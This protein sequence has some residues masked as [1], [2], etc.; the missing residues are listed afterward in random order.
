MSQ[1]TVVNRPGAS[2]GPVAPNVGKS[3]LTTIF[4]IVFVDILGFGLILPLL[5]YY[6]N[7][8]GATT[9]ITGLLV[10]SYAAAQL[11]GAPLLGRLSD[12]Y[13]RR[14]ILLVSIAGTALGFLL[15]GLA[16]P[17][18]RS[19]GNLLGIATA[20]NG[21]VLALMFASRVL[22]GLTGGNISVA[23]AYITDVTTKENRAVGLG[24]IGA[25]FG[26]GFIL[27]PAA[28]GLLSQFG[29][30]VPAYVAAGIA[31]LNVVAVYLFLPESLT[32]EKRLEMRE[33]ER[34]RLNFSTLAAAFR[35]PRVGPLLNTRFWFGMAFSMFQSI[36]SIYAA[37]KPLA[38]SPVGTGLV[39]TYVG[40]LAAIVQGFAI[41][42]ITRRY[43]DATLLISAAGA[44]AV[45]FV[46]WGA[47]PNV[48]TL[49]IVLIPLSVGGGILNTLLSSVLTKVVEPEEVGGTL[50]LATSVE[51]LTRVLAPAL[52]GALL[53]WWGVWGPAL[54]AAIVMAWV[55]YF[56]MR[57][58][59]GEV[60]AAQ[61][62]QGKPAAAA[63]SH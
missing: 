58:I 43:S 47:V 21:I 13:G 3:R 42:K 62:A 18:G 4:L 36:F 60:P 45:G 38:L 20:V 53:T 57:R 29:Y 55:T 6:A 41:G 61:A 39:L 50:G 35:R 2:H 25:A 5:P 31:T 15:L 51:S 32:P 30:A 12:R 59:A 49:L 54:F 10:A 56:I 24:L 8:Y 7:Q 63:I 44:M 33:F 16:E 34:P 37:G 27:G 48:L 9:W 11:I 28:G 40:V 17:I 23:Q 46:L 1:E 26:F 14:P 22:D 19:L 52:G